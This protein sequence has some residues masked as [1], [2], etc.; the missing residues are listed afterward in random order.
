MLSLITSSIQGYWIWSLCTPRVSAPCPDDHPYRYLDLRIATTLQ[1]DFVALPC[2]Q[3]KCGI[4]ARQSR[5]S[6]A[7][8]YSRDVD[9]NYKPTVDA[10]D[11]LEYIGSSKVSTIFPNGGVCFAWHTSSLRMIRG[12]PLNRP[13][14]A[15]TQPATSCTSGFRY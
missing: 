14:Q 9:A 10:A 2:P 13:G 15:A 11:D 3:S 1:L 8:Y 12:R 5:I 4:P 7:P 6:G